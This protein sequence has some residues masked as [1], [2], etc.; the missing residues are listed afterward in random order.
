MATDIEEV[1]IVD[2]TTDK[3][4]KEPSRYKVVIFNDDYTT[5]EFVILLLVRIFRHTTDSA[6]RITQ[7]IHDQGSGVAGIYS[8][9]IAEQK[10]ID[11]TELS[12]A[13]N[14]PLLIKAVPE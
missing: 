14:F 7:E 1:V 4:I 5:V 9:E 13:N 12:R 8:Y 10:V 3:R 2:N 11:A 6:I